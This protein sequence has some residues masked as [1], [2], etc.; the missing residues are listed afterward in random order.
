MVKARA[1]QN[2]LHDQAKMMAARIAKG[3]LPEPSPDLQRF[4]IQ[5]PSEIFAAAE[6]VCRHLPPR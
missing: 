1:T 5:N 2:D 6:G 4:L 3:R